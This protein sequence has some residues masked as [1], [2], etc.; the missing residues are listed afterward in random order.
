MVGRLSSINARWAMVTAGAVVR[1]GLAFFISVVVVRALGPTDYGVFVTLGA[2]AAIAGGLADF[3]LSDS[4]VPR[5]V[6]GDEARPTARSFFWLRVVISVIVACIGAAILVGIGWPTTPLPVILTALGLIATATAGA[7][8]TM[9]Q[10]TNRFGVFAV[11]PVVN[12]A[13]TLVAALALVATGNLNLATVLIWLGIVPS[14]LAAVPAFFALPIAFRPGAPFIT[15]PRQ[16]IASS[17]WIGAANN[18]AVV[19]VSL[20]VIVLGA[21]LGP[22]AAGLY[23]LALSLAGKADVLSGSLYSVLLPAAARREG[24]GGRAHLVR[25]GIAMVLVLGGALVAGPFIG[26]VYGPDYA[27]AAIL[28]V[29]LLAAVAL[30]IVAAP[31]QPLAIT[32]GRTRLLTA[33]EGLCCAVAIGSLFLLIPVLGLV[34]AAVARILGRVTHIL[35]VGYPAISVYR[36]EK[37]E[38]ARSSV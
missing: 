12:S 5:L 6:V 18:L 31:L 15:G 33:G 27:G 1:L 28:V 11:L 24:I 13:V 38:A 25:G 35:V 32:Q 14:V 29:W 36:A 37:R 17:A 10:A 21:M 19:S 2:L 9:L 20:D 23:G 16:W 3:G 30:D 22:V 7:V 26:A 4:A 8:A 34:G